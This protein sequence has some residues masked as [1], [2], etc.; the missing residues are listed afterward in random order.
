MKQQ[1]GCERYKNVSENEKERF[2]EYRK[3]YDEM[4]KSDYCS[5]KKFYFKKYWLRKFFWWKIN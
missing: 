5:Y 4:G 2:V 3:K 1:Y